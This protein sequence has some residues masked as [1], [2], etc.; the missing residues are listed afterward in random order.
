MPNS[1]SK[2]PKEPIRVMVRDEH[3]PTLWGYGVMHEWRGID[4]SAG[5][6]EACVSLGGSESAWV[7][8]DRLKRVGTT[9]N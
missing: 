8:G 6:W 2:H 3:K 4:E 7:A 5:T 1:G 9:S